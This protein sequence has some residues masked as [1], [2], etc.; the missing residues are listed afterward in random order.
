MYQ[1]ETENIRLRRNSQRGLLNYSLIFFITAFGIIIVGFLGRGGHWLAMV[2]LMVLF[3]LT[4][5]PWILINKQRRSYL[6]VLLLTQVLMF[7]LEAF[8]LRLGLFNVF[9]Y[10]EE[11]WHPLIS[12]EILRKAGWLVILGNIAL[13]V[14]YVL[15]F[16]KPVGERLHVFF[17]DWANKVISISEFRIWLLFFIGLAARF[18]IQ[19]NNLG[20]YFSYDANERIGAL[21]YIQYIWLIEN[22]TILSLVVYFCEQLQKG[23][24]ANWFGFLL[25]LLLELA[26]VFLGGF[27]GAVIFRIIYLA[28][29]Y[30]YIR[31]E[32]PWKLAAAGLMILILIMPVNLM[33]R[34]EYSSGYSEIESGRISTIVSGSFSALGSVISDET[35][36]SFVSTPERFI[37]Q[38]AQLQDFS[39]A[40]QFVDRTGFSMNGAELL[41]IFF[42]FIPRAIWPSKPIVSLGGWFNT[43]VYGGGPNNAAAITVPGDFYL[44][45]GWLGV[46][47]GMLLYGALLRVITVG[48]LETK[49]S[50]RLA[51]L[52]PFIVLGLGQ[53]SSEL[54]GH[55]GGLIRQLIFFTIIL[56]LFLLPSEAKITASIEGS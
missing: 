20:G 19:S 21:A 27:K 46:P 11:S 56:T 15:P 7:S 47:I 5:V 34:T 40:V 44:N 18:Y 37:R 23:R 9:R 41:N 35:E 49:A 53:P 10:L 52:V 43:E 39:M 24:K 38:S 32:F 50:I 26:T 55:L 22:L 25:M 29:A 2:Y 13:W 51:S 45:F 8:F 3:L 42:S 31:E 1:I 6:T 33:M 54:G 36:Y 17:K 12:Q 30:A 14:G 28:I 4:I 48:L 16:L